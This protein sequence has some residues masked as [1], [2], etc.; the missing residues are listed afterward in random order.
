MLQLLTFVANLNNWKLLLGKP[1]I[2]KKL[3]HYWGNFWNKV[4]LPPWNVKHLDWKLSYLKEFNVSFICSSLGDMLTNM[5]VLLLPPRQFCRRCV[6]LEF[7]YGTWEFFWARAMMTFPRLDRDLLMFWASVSLIPSLPLSLTL[8][9]PARSTWNVEINF[10]LTWQL[11]SPNGIEWYCQAQ[12][13]GH[14][15]VTPGNF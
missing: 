14:H 8:S 13:Q 15:P 5:R 3:D 9:L 11:T 12:D 7:L 2:K 6:S 1:S 4:F 10:T